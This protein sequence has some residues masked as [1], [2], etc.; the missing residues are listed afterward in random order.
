MRKVTAEQAAKIIAASVA[1]EIGDIAN[2]DCTLIDGDKTCKFAGKKV[3]P[4]RLVALVA[5]EMLRGLVP[6]G[7]KNVTT[8]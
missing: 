4:K 8:K 1:V 5:N 6:S 2:G 7:F 3:N